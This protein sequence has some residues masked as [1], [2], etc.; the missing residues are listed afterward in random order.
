MSSEFIDAPGELVEPGDLKIPKASDLAA[1]LVDAKIEFCKL[2]ECRSTD[3]T[4]VIVVDFEVEL[5]QKR[6]HDI[7]GIERIAVQ[8]EADDV[9]IPKALALR[10]DFPFVPHINISIKEFPRELCLYATRYDELKRQWTS[11]RFIERIRTWLALTAKGKLHQ[12][13]QPLEPLLWGSEGTIV[14]PSDVMTREPGDDVLFVRS[15]RADKHDSFLIGEYV[16]KQTYE[17]CDLAFVP[18][19]IECPARTHGTIRFRP[20]NLNQLA[21]FCDD[22]DF[23][24]LDRIRLAVSEQERLFDEWIEST[25]FSQS[26]RVGLKDAFLSAAVMLLMSFP[27]KRNVESVAEATDQW[28]F[29]TVHSVRDLGLDVGLWVETDGKL[30]TP[31][32]PD[33]DKTGENISLELY[34]PTF[35]LTRGLSAIYNGISSTNLDKKF[36]AVGAGALGSNVVLGLAR[37]GYGD[38]T[39][40]D[41]DY[42]N[43]HNLARHALYQGAIGWNKARFVGLMAN[44]FCEDGFNNEGLDLNVL[45]P[46]DESEKLNGFY[47][48]ADAIIDLSASVAVERHLAAD[49]ESDARR[50]SVFMNP[51]GSDLVVL[52][53]DA[54]R[55]TRLDHLEMNYYREISQNAELENHFVPSTKRIRYGQSCR[56]VSFRISNE[57]VTIHSAIACRAIRKAVESDDASISI[58]R[59]NDD[60]EVN[61]ICIE[62]TKYQSTLISDWKILIDDSLVKQMQD[63]RQSKLPNE[64]GGV[65]LGAIDFDRKKIYL[66]DTI[67]SPPDSEEWPTL[68][69]RGAKGLKSDVDAI[70]KSTD[71]AIH[72]MGEWHSHPDGCSTAP[73]DD[74]VKVFHWLTAI[75]DKDGHPALMMIVGESGTSCFVG[76]I[77]R[78]E[79]LIVKLKKKRKPRRKASC[80]KT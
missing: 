39:V 44:Q 17:K 73:S 67:P 51:S 47:K 71:G 23:S 21:E 14:L 79:N 32:A 43:P 35:N 80:Q 54:K 69:I 42:L 5:G 9:R 34:N 70:H 66:I 57:L 8:F 48:E 25:D 72:Y 4:N 16:A 6:V 19:K 29:C 22:R 52:A 60:L 41:D 58:W 1:A 18:L 49:V 26:K 15:V 37:Q 24:L 36:V 50:I 63:L 65:L 75:M 7:Q 53:E 61:R 56:D 78:V 2:V 74:D 76:E 12:D 10:A 40:V 77:L 13:D 64:T 46:D 3:T 20:S 38:W 68:Y 28:A 33:L 45:K 62:P 31:L 59:T 11:A 55:E 30:G 27:K